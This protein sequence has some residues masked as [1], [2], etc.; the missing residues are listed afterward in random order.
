MSAPSKWPLPDAG[1][2]FMTPAFMVEKLARH[3]LTKDCYPTAMGYYPHAHGHRMAR[4]RHDDNLLIY[5]TDGSGTLRTD[6]WR[7]EVRAGQLM[8]LPQGAEHFYESDSTAP[9]TLY[10]V[11]FQGASTGIFLQYLG[12]RDRRPV[13]NAGVS[14][15]LIA[16]FASLMEVRRTGYSTRAFINASNQLRHLFSQ[17]AMEISTQR[18]RGRGGV[19]L[20]DVQTFMRENIDRALSLDQLAASANMSKFHFS[21]RYKALFGYS[22]VKHFQNMKI[23]HACSL[24]DRTELTVSAIADR[25]GYDDPL[26]FSRL[27]RRTLGMSPRAYR[28]SIRQ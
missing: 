13:A 17:M 24:L 25:L 14:P 6:E 3:P 5:C 23:E 21:K 15:A 20:A 19:E 4:Q 18:G 7:G 1:I 16:A 22:P 10:W 27:F 8:L 26:Y 28:K 2:R 11:H 9:W 12:F